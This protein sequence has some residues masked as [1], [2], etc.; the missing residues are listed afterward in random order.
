M[1]RAPHLERKH[2]S[3]IHLIVAPATESSAL[4][5]V[6]G[7]DVLSLRGYV[8]SPTRCV[9][10]DID[11][12]MRILRS[13]AEA[14]GQREEVDRLRTLLFVPAATVVVAEADRRIVAAGIL[15]IRPSFRPG[16]FIGVID[17]L[18]VQGEAS[19]VDAAAA[20]EPARRNDIGASIL[21]HLVQSARNKGCTRVEVTDPL[22]AA[23]PVLFEQAGFAEQGALRSR[24]VG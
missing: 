12:T 11:A 14:G 24:A 17:V 2:F 5:R 9:T 23:E 10:T 7:H 21:E 6:P 16:P 13:A 8:C 4:D 19:D 22:A 1:I 3:G 20:A 15:S 18:A